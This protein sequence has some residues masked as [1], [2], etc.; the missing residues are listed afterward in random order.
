MIRAKTESSADVIGWIESEAANLWPAMLGS[1]SFR[2]SRCGHANCLACLSGEQH[3]SHVN[4]VAADGEKE[5]R[6]TVRA[7]FAF[8]ALVSGRMRS[9]FD[10]TE[11][12]KL[13]SSRHG[14]HLERRRIFK[15]IQDVRGESRDT[16]VVIVPAQGTGVRNRASGEYGA[17]FG[18]FKENHVRMNVPIQRCIGRAMRRQYLFGNK[19]IRV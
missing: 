15:P 10:P 14:R 18:S 8:R 13:I 5:D 1:L 2:R 4:E 9:A 12:E 7:A 17:S 6:R 19:L 16:I 3:P 11:S